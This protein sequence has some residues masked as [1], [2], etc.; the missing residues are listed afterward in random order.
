MYMCI[1]TFRTIPSLIQGWQ[2]YK[3]SS[4]KSRVKN[5][6]SELSSKDQVSEC[7]NLLHDYIGQAVID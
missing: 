5:Q 1:G 7:K 3:I 2:L 4:S 6:T